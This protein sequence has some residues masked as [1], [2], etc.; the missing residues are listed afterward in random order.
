MQIVLISLAPPWLPQQP[1]MLFPG[2]WL[3][4][5]GSMVCEFRIYLLTVDFCWVNDTLTDPQLVDD[6]VRC[7][8]FFGSSSSS[9]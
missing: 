5:D 6:G 7:K 9:W 4:G 3:T 1:D 2:P 8:S